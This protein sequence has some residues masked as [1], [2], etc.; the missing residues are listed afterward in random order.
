MTKVTPS[1]TARPAGRLSGQDRPLPWLLRGVNQRYLA[2]MR[3]TLG[4]AGMADLPQPG[5]W[6]LSALARGAGDAGDLV[7]AMGVTKQAVSKLLDTLVAAG[8]VER[9]PNARDRRKTDLVLAERGRHAVALIESA[10]AATEARFEDEV[11][12]AALGR[13]RALLDTLAAAPVTSGDD[14]PLDDQE[15][16][17]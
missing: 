2:T 11:G 17:L 5:Y 8:F 16:S 6:A 1:S 7:R 9:R 12:P 13:L 15:R 3:A 10:V 14:Q 4:E